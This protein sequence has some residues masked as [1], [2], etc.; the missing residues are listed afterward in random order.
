[1]SPSWI[2]ATAALPAIVRA[3]T[4]DSICNVDYAVASLPED[5]FYPGITIDKA[6]VSTAATTGY[7]A[8]SEWFPTTTIDY[9]NVTFAYSHDDIPGDV[10]HVS[11]WLPA[12]DNFKN[13]Y[14]STGGGG[15]AINSGTSYI[16]SGVIVGG[17]SGITDGGFG[18]FNTQ[19]DAA[20]FLANGSVNWEAVDMFGFKAHH[21]LATLGKEFTKNLFN[22]TSCTKLFSYWQ[23]CSE[24][25][26]EGWSQAQR[27]P[28]QFDG[29]AIGAPAFRY[30]EQQVNHLTSNVIEQTMDYYPP[31]CELDKITNLTIAFCDPLDGLTD[32]VV[33]RSDLCKLAFNVSSTIGES[34]S[35]EASAGTPYSAATPAQSGVVTAEGAAVAQ[36]IL[37]G[38]Y[39]SDG[40]FVYFSYQP[41]STFTDAATAYNETTDSWGLSISGLGGEWVARFLEFE[42]TTTLDSLDGF[43][44]DTLR[45]LMIQGTELYNTSQQT[46][47]PN[48][49]SLNTAGVKILHIHGE[50]DFSIPTASSVRYYDSVREYIYPQLGYNESVEA[51]DNF[52]RLFLVPGG[53][54]CT[55]FSYEA[56]GGWPQTTLQTVINW[57]ENGTAPG[58]LDNAG[59]TID[60][61]CKWPL[62]PL[63]DADGTMTCVYDQ[64]SLD[65]WTY[66]I[67]AFPFYLY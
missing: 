20:F 50:Q 40:N 37:D 5:D 43:S 4:L 2:L 55:S 59:G 49:T 13:R 62:R 38:L 47:Y 44:Y 16:P 15:L 58:T 8:E 48:L 36:A 61:I 65:T 25:G 63:W 18:S 41:G 10:V 51:L 45:D 57:V 33:S 14:I 9:C 3:A 64:A 26:R 11:Y 22:V 56:N 7:T 6:S 34:Y 27:Y 31:T 42:N 30:G 17:V 19:Y 66:D 21:E 35:C 39:D 67:D 53:S 52:Y 28:E 32:G 46:T 1:M 24:G 60:S 29:Y 12:P 54:H 23:G